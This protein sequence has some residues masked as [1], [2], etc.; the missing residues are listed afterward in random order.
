M[1]NQ[2]SIRVVG[3]ERRVLKRVKGA[4]QPVTII[5]NVGDDGRALRSGGQG[6]GEQMAGRAP[7]VAADIAARVGHAGGITHRVI[8]NLR[9]KIGRRDGIGQLA[10]I[11]VTESG[12]EATRVGVAGHVAERTVDKTF[13]AETAGIGDA[14]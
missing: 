11:V 1:S 13:A 2:S 7:S 12:N 5:I 3:V 6:G 10:A 9:D 4:N 8:R 14:V